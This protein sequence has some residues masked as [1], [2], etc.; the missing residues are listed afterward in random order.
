VAVPIGVTTEARITNEHTGS[1]TTTTTPAI[2]KTN[3]AGVSL[4]LQAAKVE[5]IATGKVV[6]VIPGEYRIEGTGVTTYKEVLVTQPAGK[7]CKVKGGTITTNTLKGTSVGMEGKLEPASGTQFAVVTIEG[8]S[9]TALN[10]P[11]PITGSIKC[12]GD[13]A[14]ILCTHTAT[15]T[16]ETLHMGGQNVGV[17]L[18]TT[19]TGRASSATGYTPL[20]VTTAP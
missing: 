11:Y 18:A 5:D 12:S 4:T 3:V 6:E 10:G 9:V 14:E 15:T 7:G 19:Y 20:G 16:Q 8:C 17:E 1:E 13:G 2:L